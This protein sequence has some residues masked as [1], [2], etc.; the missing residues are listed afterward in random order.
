TV[1][2][3][4]SKWN[5]KRILRFDWSEIFGRRE[6]ETLQ[7]SAVLLHRENLVPSD[8]EAL[9]ET[10]DEASHKHAYGVSED[11]KYSVREA[12]EKL[13]NE[14]IWYLREKR[15]EKV[16]D[17]EINERE[18][19]N[20]CLRYIYRMLFLFYIEARPELGFA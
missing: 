4:R 16:Y 11:L 1:L 12:V 9:H 17:G 18:F 8:G 10:L 2:I 3:D 7:A 6:K 14:A 19:T 5:E 20:E 13:G 15:H